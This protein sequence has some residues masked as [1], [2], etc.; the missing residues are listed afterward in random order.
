MTFLLALSPFYCSRGMGP[1][2]KRERSPLHPDAIGRHPPSRLWEPRDGSRVC[3]GPGAVLNKASRLADHSDGGSA[4]AALIDLRFRTCAGL[5]ASATGNENHIVGSCHCVASQVPGMVRGGVR[6]GLRSRMAALRR[7]GHRRSSRSAVGRRSGD[8]LRLGPLREA[9]GLMARNPR[10]ALDSGDLSGFGRRR[11]L[12]PSMRPER[13]DNRPP[14]RHRRCGTPPPTRQ[15]S[16][17]TGRPAAGTTKGACGLSGIRRSPEVLNPI[18]CGRFG[19]SPLRSGWW[20]P[21]TP[22]HR[23]NPSPA[24]ARRTKQRSS[25]C[26]PA[27]AYGRSTRPSRPA[28]GPSGSSC[29]S[30]H[31]V[32]L[33]RP[34]T[35]RA[36][37]AICC[38]GGRNRISKRPLA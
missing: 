11:G 9:F 30:E 4:S 3:Q 12:W 13:T 35:R 26:R 6:Q 16:P 14:S 31:P 36:W 29:R 27:S 10:F 34:S 19:C 21:A 1:A 15:R 38:G 22:H 5:S 33:R 7:R 20:I 28:P 23:P 37:R 8:R 17:R 2:G 18:T 32:G 24:S 25:G